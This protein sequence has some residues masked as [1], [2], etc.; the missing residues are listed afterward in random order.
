MKIEIE[1]SDF[2]LFLKA[3]NNA[4]SAY[5]DIVSSIM[6]G[7]DPQINSSRFQILNDLTNEELK[8]RMLE[9]K[10]VY[11]QFIELERRMY[12]DKRR[13]NHESNA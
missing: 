6:L 10:N 8:A 3:F 4:V 7:C 11:Y 2:N 9:L 1:V 5:G 13:E 12:D